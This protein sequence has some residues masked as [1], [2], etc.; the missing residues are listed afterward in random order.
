MY[1]EEG[2]HEDWQEPDERQYHDADSV[3]A[4]KGGDV[5]LPDDHGAGPAVWI[6]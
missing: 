2:R 4:G 1:W 3:S 5:R 6:A